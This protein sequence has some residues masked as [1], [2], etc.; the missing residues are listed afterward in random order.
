MKLIVTGALGHIGSRIIRE[1]PILFPGV[2]IVMID[3]MATQRYSS[4]FDLPAQGLYSF[5]EGDILTLDL[6]S[7][8]SEADAVIH[9]AA[10]TDATNSFNNQ[11]KVEHNNY[12]A[13]LRVSESCVTSN[14]N[15][16]LISSTSVYGTQE[17][18]VDENCEFKEL[19]PQS[20]YAETK[21][22]E[23]ALIK[24]K[25]QKEGLRAVILRLG[26]IFGTSPGMRFHTAVNKFCWQAV[27]GQP[28]TIWK[29]AFDQKRPYLDLVDAIRVIAFFLKNNKFDGRVY[30]VV[31]LNST[32]RE[33]VGIIRDFI[34]ALNTEFVDSQIMNQLSYEVINKRLGEES[35]VFQGD[36]KK[37]IRNTILLL[38]QSMSH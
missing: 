2:E 21:L 36:I 29:T 11:E 27:M 26:T 28:L 25:I 22:K 16:F 30:N 9:L 13:S 10:I 37:G 14:V 34:P 23:E 7:L 12:T 19:K 3:N 6:D 31:T 18:Q 8:F 33:M 35:F 20:P 15:M 32:V 5:I 17:K 1:L 4:L 24:T 38:K